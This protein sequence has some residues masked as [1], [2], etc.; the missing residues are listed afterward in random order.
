MSDQADCSMWT[1]SR[2]LILRIMSI[3]L[4]AQAARDSPSEFLGGFFLGLDRE[5]L[6]GGVILLC[7]MLL[8]GGYIN[9]GYE[10]YLRCIYDILD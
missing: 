5:I 10:G 4:S 9:V 1:V 7:T 8:C 6:P 3:I 2:D